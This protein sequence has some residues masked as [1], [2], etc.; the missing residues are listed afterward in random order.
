MRTWILLATLC[1]CAGGASFAGGPAGA[2]SFRASDGA[3]SVEAAMDEGFVGEAELHVPSVVPAPSSAHSRQASTQAV[4][5]ENPSGDEPGLAEPRSPS[6]SLHLIYTA[7]L[8]I[9]VRHGE[10]SAA[11]DGMLAATLAEGGYLSRRDTGVLVLRVPSARFRTVLRGLKGYGEVTQWRVRVQD[12]SEEFHDLEVRI[13]SLTTL[14]ERMRGL[15][16]RASTLEEVLRIEGE[17]GRITTSI[18]AARGRLRYLR[19][20]VAWSTVT[21]VVTEGPAPVVA[22]APPAVSPT[23]LT[24]PIEWLNRTG[25]RN[26]LNLEND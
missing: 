8:G 16:E 15:L 1:G 25:L 7:D 4:V 18:D 17:I 24:L 10:G 2:T 13:E 11:L 14:L 20:H 22:E 3:Y 12:V 9:R 23:T 26:L 19:S 6:G 5:E 21:V